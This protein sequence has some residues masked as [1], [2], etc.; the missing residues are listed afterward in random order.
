MKLGLSPSRIC[1][2]GLDTKIFAN[3]ATTLARNILKE[4]LSFQL[5]PNVSGTD[6]QLRV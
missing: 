4:V 2:D 6:S 1:A 3:L 5:R